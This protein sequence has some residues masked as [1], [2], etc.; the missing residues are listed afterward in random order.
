MQLI[1]CPIGISG[2]EVLTNQNLPLL[3]EVD[4]GGDSYLNKKDLTLLSVNLPL[5]EVFHLGHFEHSDYACGQTVMKKQG[6]MPLKGLFVCELL[7]K[8]NKHFTA[9]KTLFLEQ[10]CDLTDFIIFE[11]KKR[12]IRQNDLLIKFDLNQSNVE[13]KMNPASHGNRLDHI[14]GD[15]DVGFH[16]ENRVYSDGDNSGDEKNYF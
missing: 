15:G 13:H 16:Y 10:A 12:K 8:K 5:M 1:S 3:R 2:C 4:F 9:L 11:L 6:E 14:I 7:K